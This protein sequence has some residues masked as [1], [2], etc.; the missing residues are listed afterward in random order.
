MIYRLQKKFIL[1]CTVSVLAVVALVFAAFLVL[2]ISTMNRNMDILAERVSDGGGRFPDYFDEKP[3][4][5]KNPQKNGKRFDFITPETPFAT[6]HFSVFFKD[7][8][9]VTKIFTESI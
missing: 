1:I 7:E 8:E 9:K 3:V 2:N 4:P 5:D 6:R